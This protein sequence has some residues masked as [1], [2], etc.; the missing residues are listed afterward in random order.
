MFREMQK[1][2]TIFFFLLHTHS[3]WPWTKYFFTEC[4]A[5]TYG[6]EC[7]NLCGNCYNEIQCNH[8]NGNCQNGCDVGF[9]G[10]KCNKGTVKY[11]LSNKVFLLFKSYQK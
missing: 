5:G 11:I 9:F 10:E 7:G 2:T 6:F 1:L 4:S 8:V 3:T